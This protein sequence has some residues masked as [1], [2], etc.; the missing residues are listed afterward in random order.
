MI[1]HPNKLWFPNFCRLPVV[2]A[3]IVLAELVVIVMLLAAARDTAQLK[4]QL[5]LLSLFV[6]WIALLAAGSLCALRQ[7]LSR[8]S[9]IAGLICAWLVI[10]II[11]A[12]C[13]ALGG[14]L[15]SNL[16]LPI[17]V[18]A[19]ALRHNVLI[20]GLV[21]AAALRYFYVQQ[22]WRRSIEAEAEA[23]VR[24]LQARIRPHFLFNSMNTIASLIRSRPE[25][26]ERTVEDLSELFRRV[27]G[28]NLRQ[29][30]LG[31]EMAMT[32]RYLA[33]EALRLGDRLTLDW[34]IDQLPNDQALP[35]LI[36]QP[37]VENAIYHGIEGLVD[38]GTLRVVGEVDDRYWRVTIDNPCGGDPRPNAGHGMAVDNTRQRLQHFFSGRAA[39]TVEAT[40][41]HYSVTVQAPLRTDSQKRQGEHSESTHR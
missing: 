13:S 7:Q 9:P 40:N 41:A 24:G 3:V 8:L 35:P 25:V 15:S 2:F 12:V 32:R 1:E 31:E 26:A 38:G 19:T 17:E 16:V 6:Q 21:A 4:A 23:R 14:W 30:T 5:P 29:T 33:I 28:E 34:R 10:V 36:F 39:L 27:L 37:L 20:A 22:Q 18:S 11:T